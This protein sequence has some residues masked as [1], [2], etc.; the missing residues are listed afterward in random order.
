MAPTQDMILGTYYMTI[1]KKD[2]KGTNSVFRDLDEMEM[3]Y[4]NKDVELHSEVKVRIT[5]EIDGETD[6]SSG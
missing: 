2:G 3:A 5:K 1:Y 6:D 4:F